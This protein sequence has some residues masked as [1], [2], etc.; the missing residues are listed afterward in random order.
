MRL[1][2]FALIPVVL[3]LNLPAATAASRPGL[4]EL[5]YLETDKSLI[6]LV[7]A[8]EA[9]PELVADQIVVKLAAGPALRATALPENGLPEGVPELDATLALHGIQEG[10]RVRRTHGTPIRNME[11]FLELGFDRLYVL[12]LPQ[13]DPTKALRLVEELSREP[14]VEYAHAVYRHVET[15]TPNDTFFSTQWAHH[16]TG[17]ADAFGTPD[18]DMDSVQAWDTNPGDATGT[19]AILDTGIQMGGTVVTHPDLVANVDIAASFDFADNDPYPED[20]NG[21][22]T[23]AAGVA[24]AVGNNGIG[25]AGMCH[26]CRILVYKVSSSVE[27]SRCSKNPGKRAGGPAS[28][29][30]VTG[31]PASTSVLRLRRACCSATR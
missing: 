16:N 8:G 27:S 15:L 14:W 28:V 23:G 10:F 26:G 31:A 29:P 4:P 19:V 11:L 17:Q 30:K 18:A 6:R 5:S 22:G 24:A 20:T 7:P 12:K 25:V 1:S 21:H 13:A 9:E 3:G 2:V